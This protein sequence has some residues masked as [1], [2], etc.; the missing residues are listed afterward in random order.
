[1]REVIS[2]KRDEYVCIYAWAG[3]ALMLDTC[4]Q[5]V[6]SSNI[7]RDT[8]IRVEIRIFS[9]FPQSRHLDRVPVHNAFIICHSTHYSLA[10]DSAV[11]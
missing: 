6:L 5:K 9:S 7:G 8:D 1:V 11:K 3:V 2:R 10:T 4:I